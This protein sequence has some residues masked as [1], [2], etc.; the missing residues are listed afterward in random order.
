MCICVF[1][2]AG[3]VENLYLYFQDLQLN[4]YLQDL[5]LNIFFFQY[6]EFNLYFQDLPMGKYIVCG[7]GHKEGH[8][9]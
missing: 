9:V 1:V 8:V 5:Q 7:E 6:L 2:F 3:P 4:L